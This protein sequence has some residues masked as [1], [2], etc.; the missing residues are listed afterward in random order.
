MAHVSET[1]MPVLG[2]G[3]EATI[4]LDA[5]SGRAVKH[6]DRAPARIARRKAR[7]EFARLQE[8][9][10]LSKNSS[11]VRVPEPG[12]LTG[13]IPAFSMERIEGSSLL[14]LLATGR[15]RGKHATQIARHVAEGMHLFKDILADC[16]LDHI[17]PADDGSVTFFDFGNGSED[18]NGWSPNGPA[19]LF[20][21]LAGSTLYECSRVARYRGPAELDEIARFLAALACELGISWSE[22]LERRIWHAFAGRGLE[23]GFLRYIWYRLAGGYNARRMFNVIRTMVPE[24]AAPS[25]ET[26]FSFVWDF[27]LEQN[28]VTNGVHKV[29]DGLMKALSNEGVNPVVITFGEDRATL[30]RGSY[31]VEVYPR[32]GMGIPSSLI[33][34][35][36]REGESAVTILNGTFNTW[37]T[38]LAR[39]LHRHHLPYV[40]NPHTIMDAGF[41]SVSSIKKQLYWTL[42]ERRVL[43]HARAI[44]SFDERHRDLLAAKGVNVPVICSWNG[45]CDPVLPQTD[46]FTTDG[47][48]RFHFFGRISTRT[49]GLD[50]LLEATAEVAHDHALEVTIQGPGTEDLPGLKE[51]ARTLG[52]EHLIRFEPPASS[53]NPI[54]IMAKY[55][56]CV[57]PSRYEGFPTALVEALMA[58][59]PIVTT[60]VGTLA[61]QL[62]AEDL[63]IVVDTSSEA[64]ADGMRLA[65]QE[66]E[67]WPVI[68]PQGRAWAMNHLQWTDISR[69]LISDLKSVLAASS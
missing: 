66:R 69:T 12:E 60:R 6:F 14:D 18:E 40:V 15:L 56:V 10:S 53:P 28:A 44:I 20:E 54:L 5:N 7:T 50:M 41:F 21:E 1:S 4:Y 33:D 8:A 31:F 65:I 27:P 19:A 35:I 17:H 22:R 51:A 59:R 55:D 68:G 9:H 36:R 39:T 37:N 61:P 38:R 29:V 13:G 48:V 26:V 11:F 43:N 62:E 45:I 30:D 32:R 24:A 23:G 57:L 34:R 3:S 16:T 64:I 67:R 63:A 25:L 47:P 42:F 46:Q 58:A 2:R 49:K 52:I